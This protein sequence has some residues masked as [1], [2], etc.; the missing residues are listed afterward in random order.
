M[1][2]CEGNVTGGTEG[3][4]RVFHKVGMCEMGVANSLVG[5]GS[6][7]ASVFMVQVKPGRY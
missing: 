6:L 7:P 1:L 3:Q 2:N 4:I 5:K